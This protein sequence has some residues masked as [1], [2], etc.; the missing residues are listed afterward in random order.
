MAKSQYLETDDSPISFVDMFTRFTPITECILEHLPNPCPLMRTCKAVH[1][2]VLV[3]IPS[4][5]VRKRA[6]NIC[7]ERGNGFSLSSAP[8]VFRVDKGLA[9]IAIYRT[10]LD[11]SL[12]D[13][14]LQNDISVVKIAIAS[15]L[16]WTP[17]MFSKLVV[18]IPQTLYESSECNDF[19]EHICKGEPVMGPN[20]KHNFA[21]LF[22]HFPDDRDIC[23]FAILFNGCALRFASEQLRNDREI[24]LAA[25]KQDG[26]ALAYANEQLENDREI[27]LAAV[28]QNGLVLFYHASEQL[29]NDREIVLAAVK[30]NGNALFYASEQLKNDRE[31]ILATVVDDDISL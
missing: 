29:K 4:D 3:Y 25:V 22:R 15:A 1:R 8:P 6:P 16:L 12:L 21:S 9:M 13:P 5:L 30:Q 14:C 18:C 27:V 28:N 20:D 26:H 23:L 10:P 7:I 31:I 24:V 19:V 17:L 2:M 11:Y